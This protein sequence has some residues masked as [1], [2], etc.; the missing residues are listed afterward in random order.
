MAYVLCECVSIDEA[1][2]Q[3]LTGLCLVILVC[4]TSYVV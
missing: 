3:W 2:S 1:A 4:W